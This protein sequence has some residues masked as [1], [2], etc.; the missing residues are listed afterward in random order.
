[1]R[2]VVS[3]AS[4]DIIRR[5]PIF[6]LPDMRSGSPSTSDATRKFCPPSFTVSP[7][8]TPSES[9]GPRRSPRNPRAARLSA[10]SADPASL[11]RSTDTS[12]G[13]T[14]FT[15]IQHRGRVLSQRGRHRH[16]LGDERALHSWDAVELRLTAR[17]SA[18]QTVWPSGPRHYGA[19]PRLS[20]SER[21]FG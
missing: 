11:R 17:R 2:P 10:V 13:S 19:R 8:F 18:T 1:M 21:S 3:K 15:E 5:R 6:K 20:A 12:T 16:R 14:A 9:R 4:R 7:T